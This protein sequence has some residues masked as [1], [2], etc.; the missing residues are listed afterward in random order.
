MLQLKKLKEVVCPSRR[1]C[2]R[3]KALAA[4]GSTLINDGYLSFERAAYAR[5]CDVHSW[6]EVRDVSPLPC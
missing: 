3:A 5:V 2:V 1:L 4:V 6:S